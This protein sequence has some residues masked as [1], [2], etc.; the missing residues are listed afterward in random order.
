MTLLWLVGLHLPP[1]T[2]YAVPK[3][4][5][6][7]T[8]FFCTHV[9]LVAILGIANQKSGFQLNKMFLDELWN[10]KRRFNQTFQSLVMIGL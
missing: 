10:L 6:F 9:F 4:R 5:S 2:P 8:E 1:F 3:G 7:T